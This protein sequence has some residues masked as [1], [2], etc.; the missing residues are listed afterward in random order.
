[1]LYDTIYN[2]FLGLFNSTSLA[3]YESEIMGVSTTLPSWLSHTITIV[4]L[5]LLV[6]FLGLVVRYIFRVFSGVIH[7]F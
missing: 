5:V 4:V 6:V 3:Q 7:R 2:Y 1:M